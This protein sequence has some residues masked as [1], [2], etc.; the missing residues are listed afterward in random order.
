[1][2]TILF[3]FFCRIV[4]P[5]AHSFQHRGSEKPQLTT[6][7]VPIDKIKYKRLETM[8]NLYFGYLHISSQQT[9]QAWAI[10][11]SN[12]HVEQL[13]SRAVWVRAWWTA[14]YVSQPSRDA[15]AR[16][17]MNPASLFSHESYDVSRRFLH[18]EVAHNAFLSSCFASAS[19]DMAAV[20]QNCPLFTWWLNT[21]EQQLMISNFMN[22]QFENI[23]CCSNFK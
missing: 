2:I 11:R 5:A 3:S 10:P 18:R 4:C 6:C 14:G 21:E 20:V 15:R 19:L 22:Y 23:I 13:R 7:F 9:P 8:I 17:D 1:M 12:E 16:S